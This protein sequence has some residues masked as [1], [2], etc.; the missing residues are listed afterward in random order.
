MI[1]HVYRHPC[2][3][4]CMLM[5][6]VTASH[7]NPIE[8]INIMNSG[9]AH[10]AEWIHANGLTLN[11]TKCVYMIFLRTRKIDNPFHMILN[12][13]QL[14]KVTT[15]KFQGVRWGD[16]LGWIHHTESVAIQ[17]SKTNGIIYRIRHL[18]DKSAL[19]TLY[20]NMINP[21]LTY[22]NIFCGGTAASYLQQVCVA[23][24]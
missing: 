21:R 2:N 24:K 15:T 3:I 10:I 20:Y 6:A 4:P 12:N 11:L 18:L 14:E 23:Q 19:I 22:G 8:A 9:L 7:C 1:Y 13:K 5:R 16:G 17:M